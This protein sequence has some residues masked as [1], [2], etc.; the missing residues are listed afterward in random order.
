MY[1]NI[2]QS[3]IVVDKNQ[4]RYYKIILI[5]LKSNKI[6]KRKKYKI[7]LFKNY[8]PKNRIQFKN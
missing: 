3:Y 7:Y 4:I 6:I 8:L 5:L 2:N 1:D